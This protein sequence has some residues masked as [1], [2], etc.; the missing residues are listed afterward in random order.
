M[1][2]GPFCSMNYGTP[3][4]N[5]TTRSTYDNW[6]S[7]QVCYVYFVDLWLFF[8]NNVYVLNNAAFVLQDRVEQKKK[9]IVEL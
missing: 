9:I 1:W 2:Y 8:F 7:F 4:H 5:N 6:N 3:K